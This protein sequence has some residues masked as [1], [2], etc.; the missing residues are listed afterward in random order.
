MLVFLAA[1]VLVVPVSLAGTW[2]L[3]HLPGIL[4]TEV[5]FQSDEVFT[6]TADL[7]LW[8]T[9]FGP[10]HVYAAGEI[11]GNVMQQEMLSVEEMPAGGAPESDQPMRCPPVC[12]RRIVRKKEDFWTAAF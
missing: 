9:I 12:S 10:V 11:P 2:G 4:G 7:D 8:E 6:T 3:T 1:A 5:R